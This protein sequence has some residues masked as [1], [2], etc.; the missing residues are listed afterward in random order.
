MM[1][2][3]AKKF[4]GGNDTELSQMV[5]AYYLKQYPATLDFVLNFV[6]G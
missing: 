5:I 2:F 3:I 4:K 6:P 1:G